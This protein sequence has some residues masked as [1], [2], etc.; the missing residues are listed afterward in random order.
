MLLLFVFVD[1]QLYCY[2]H[3]LYNAINVAR[4]TGATYYFD[5]TYCKHYYYRL[6]CCS[7]V[8]WLR[9]L[10]WLILPQ[11]ILRDAFQVQYGI[12]SDFVPLASTSMPRM[13]SKLGPLLYQFWDSKRDK[14]R[15]LHIWAGGMRKIGLSLAPLPATT[16]K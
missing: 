6:H 10:I 13:S 12:G 7:E 3:A 16:P 1:S 9:E 2:H 5:G 8:D 4:K 11:T 14:F 15:E